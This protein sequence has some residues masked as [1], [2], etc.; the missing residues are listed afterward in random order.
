M[1]DKLQELYT[2]AITLNQL[3]SQ[4]SQIDDNTLLNLM[5]LND[6]ADLD[7]LNRILTAVYLPK[8]EIN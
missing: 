3:K 4:S 8:L 5:E 2:K 7:F 1:E 6:S